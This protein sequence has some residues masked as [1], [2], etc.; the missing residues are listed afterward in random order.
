MISDCLV[1]LINHRQGP[2]K[3]IPELP[4]LKRIPVSKPVIAFF[5]TPPASR[6]LRNLS[7]NQLTVVDSH[8]PLHL[9]LNYL[10]AS[11]RI[12]CFTPTSTRTSPTKMSTAAR[13]RL[14][15]DFKVRTVY[16]D[17]P[18]CGDPFLA[19]L[20]PAAH[21]DRSACWRLRV[22]RPRQC[23]DM[24]SGYH[25][26][27]TELSQQTDAT[28]HQERCHYWPRGYPL[29]GWNVPA[30]DELRRAVPE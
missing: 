13:R 6:S 30:R 15:R 28:S 2:A 9:A 26:D 19:N 4:Q 27:T 1:C 25:R 18:G 24:V 11:P 5:D 12:L 8:Q 17:K 14:M 29:R 20:L 23:H 22:P 3:F 10:A 16:L 7:F 21:A